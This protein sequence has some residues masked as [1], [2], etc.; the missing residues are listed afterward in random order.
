M[1]Q[2]I[3]NRILFASEILTTGLSPRAWMPFAR[4]ARALRA[5]ATGQAA[6]FFGWFDGV[7]PRLV[8]TSSQSQWSLLEVDNFRRDVGGFQERAVL[9]QFGRR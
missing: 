5:M 2:R 3:G 4:E 6:T 7:G 8:L 9:S 1:K